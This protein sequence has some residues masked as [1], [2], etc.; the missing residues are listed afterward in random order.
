MKYLS[1]IGEFGFIDK[2]VARHA[3]S[4]QG[5]ISV[6]DDCSVEPIDEK[7]ARLVT[8]D[9]L[10]ENVHF[11]KKAIR[12]RELGY[13]ALA[14]N[15][16]DIAA[17]GGKPE[18]IH[19]SVAFP[20][21][22]KID[23]LE[24]FYSGIHELAD[25]YDAGIMG[26]DTTSSPNNIII[27][28]VVS[29]ILEREKIKYRSGAQ[30]GDIICVNKYVGDS[31]A[32]LKLILNDI[33]I[34]SEDEKYLIKAHNH[35]VAQLQ[36]GQFLAENTAVHAMLD[37]SDGIGSDI[38]HIMERSKKGARINLEKIPISHQLQNMAKKR[39]WNALDLAINGGEDYCLLFTVDPEEFEQL[40]QNYQKQFDQPIFNI[41]T[42]KEQKYGLRY[43]KK[44]QQ[45]KFTGHGF[46]HFH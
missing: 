29:G 18:N 33:N 12:A 39:G 31:A 25:Q 10:V 36:Q 45:Q 8:T 42:I 17:M 15:F 19:I 35:P 20:E 22:T 5:S 24:E 16:S 27:N 28:I 40:K 44:D 23:W 13:K 34:E 32:G 7:F 4:K 21:N 1:E 3:R 11:L 6:G 38:E 9:L 41:G 26:G 46:D 37:V 14:V 43:F 2:I 30:L